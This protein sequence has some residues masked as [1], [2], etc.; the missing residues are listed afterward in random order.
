MDVLEALH[1]GGLSAEL[2]AHCAAC[3]DCADL[4]LAAGAL[5][6]QPAAPPGPLASAGFVWW[7]GQIQARLAQQQRAERPLAIAEVA[8]ALAAIAGGLYLWAGWAGA[9]TVPALALPAAL[10]FYRRAYHSE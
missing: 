8:G 2:H 6:E 5:L 1:A 3:A 7:K 10:W 4:A 9:L